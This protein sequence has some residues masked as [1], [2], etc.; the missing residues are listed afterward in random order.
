MAKLKP[1]LILIP[2]GLAT[3][4]GGG[5]AMG[6]LK[7]GGPPAAEAL[8]K[9][10][11]RFVTLGALLIPVLLPDGQLTA[12]VTI[13][14]QLEVDVAD[15]EGATERVPLIIHAVNLRTF[16][17]PLAAGPDGR[18]PDAGKVRA[19]VAEEAAQVL[20]KGRVKSV[21]L[22]RLAPA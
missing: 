14:V 18:L 1:W 16:Q 7:P 2:L 10:D 4:A 17:T 3:G 22:T 12:Y 20:G 11:G 5:A 6:F 21:A 9:L 13:E 19:L 15:E 8:T